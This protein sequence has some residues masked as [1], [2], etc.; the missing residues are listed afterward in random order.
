MTGT[1]NRDRWMRKRINKTIDIINSQ[2]ELASLIIKD[3]PFH[4]R[5][6]QNHPDTVVELLDESCSSS[7]DS[8]N[9]SQDLDS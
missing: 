2:H 7:D 4:H 6:N 3:N 9:D 8:S 5:P 1:N